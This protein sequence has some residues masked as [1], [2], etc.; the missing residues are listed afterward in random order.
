MMRPE[1]LNSRCVAM[2]ARF[3][4]AAKPKV[5]M[6]DGGAF[7]ETYTLAEA[8]RLLGVSYTTAGRLLKAEAGVMRYRTGSDGSVGFGDT[9]LKRLQ[10]V[11]LTW[12]IPEG[13]I[14]RLIE[15]MSLAA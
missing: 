11:R 4:G 6:I 15:R 9:K 8:A 12:V 2:K 3:L 7:E 10:R 14:R 1:V 13:V 5:V